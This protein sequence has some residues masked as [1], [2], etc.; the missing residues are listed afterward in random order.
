MEKCS[1]QPVRQLTSI[2]GEQTTDFYEMAIL[3]PHYAIYQ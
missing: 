3:L 2:I 1:K